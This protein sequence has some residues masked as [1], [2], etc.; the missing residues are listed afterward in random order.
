MVASIPG[1]V[2]PPIGAA[3]PAGALAVCDELERTQWLSPAELAARQR[4]QLA[5]VLA[6]A[7]SSVPHYAGIDPRDFASVPVMTR[8]QIIAARD[9]L[10]SRAYP[11]PH[12]PTQELSTSRTSGEPVRVRASAVVTTMH[13]AITLRD[14]RW[15]RR[16]LHVSLA[17]LRYA[18][19]APG[20]DGATGRGWGPVTMQLAPDAPA[21]VLSI[22]G[23]TTDE[24]LAWL[25]RK[26]PTYLLTYPSVLHA[27]LRRIA[28]T[29][30]RL[31]ALREV[32]T[33][34]EAL[35]P[36]TR[37]LCREVL[38]VPIVD[39]YSAQ[40]VG[41][42]ALQCPASEHYHVQ[43]ERHV[44]EILRDDGTA[45]VPGE[46]GRVVITDL[47]N[48]ATPV[49]RYDIGDLAELAPACP[50]GRGLPTLARIVGRV[51][52]MLLRPDGST[53]Y[54]VFT[55]ACREAARYRDIQ[56]VQLTRETLRARVVPDGELDER[57]LI[58]AIHRTLGDHFAVEVERVDEIARTAGGKLEEFIC[59]AT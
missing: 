16:D 45:C 4:E 41:Y 27:L 12:G 28:A 51:R 38:D 42:I 1:I 52:N 56:L 57:A 44:V 19:N 33:V 43:S 54:P 47:H 17:S 20:P 39:V 29:S 49:I 50:C 31:S 21:H 37:G 22:I 8:A 25:V 7:A 55:V 46:I 58:D 3:T 30:T 6:H 26:N 36:G 53:T 14:H 35:T 11:V 2:W 34:G 32:R 59:Q 40:E 15:H 24:Q 48:F 9:R 13:A 10:L 5:V 18:P 23:T